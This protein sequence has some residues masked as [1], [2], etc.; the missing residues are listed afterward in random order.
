M[1]TL[2]YYIPNSSFQLTYSSKAPSSKVN[3]EDEEDLAT[4]LVEERVDNGVFDC[5]KLNKKYLKLLETF[6]IMNSSNSDLVESLAEDL[7]IPAN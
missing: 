7:N 4:D 6:Q 1:E 2:K 3:T 5:A